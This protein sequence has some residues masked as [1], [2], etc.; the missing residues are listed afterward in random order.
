MQFYLWTIKSLPSFKNSCRFICQTVAEINTCLTDQEEWLVHFM[1]CFTDP[2]YRPG[3]HPPTPPHPHWQWRVS[4]YYFDDPCADRVTHQRFVPCWHRIPS[5]KAGHLEGKLPSADLQVDIRVTEDK[6]YTL[7]CFSDFCNYIYISASL[8]LQCC[9]M[10]LFKVEL[11]FP[12]AAFMCAN[13]DA[14]DVLRELSHEPRL[15]AFEAQCTVCTEIVS[16][17]AAASVLWMSYPSHWSTAVYI[18]K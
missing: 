12:R 9:V 15:L 8:S 2:H 13:R 4:P 11:R 1:T 7:L 16:G 10:C 18:K 6:L 3:H 17:T 14:C 5:N